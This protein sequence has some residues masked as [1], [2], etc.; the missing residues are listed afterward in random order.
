MSS[1]GGGGRA[2]VN[3]VFTAVPPRTHRHVFQPVNPGQQTGGRHG[4]RH[5]YCLPP[6]HH[7]RPRRPP[8]SPAF[9]HPACSAAGWAPELHIWEEPVSLRKAPVLCGTLPGLTPCDSACASFAATSV[10]GEREKSVALQTSESPESH[11]AWQTSAEARQLCPRAPRAYPA[12]HGDP[13]QKPLEVAGGDL[14]MCRAGKNV[15]HR[16]EPWGASQ[17]ALGASVGQ[18]H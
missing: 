1:S 15:P 3:S 17:P 4:H 11:S 10:Q 2:S 7:C 14:L 5:H 13:S 18:S 6:G 8:R 12:V 9:I 16:S